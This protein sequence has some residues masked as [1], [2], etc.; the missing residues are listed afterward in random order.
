MQNVDKCTAPRTA[1][2]R[3]IMKTLGERDFSAQETMHLLLSLKL[4]ST[5]FNVIPVSLNGSRKVETQQNGS[6][7]CTKDS[8]LDKYAKRSIYKQSFPEIMNVNFVEFATKYNIV[9]GKLV[10][11][12]AIVVPRIFPTYSPNPKGEN[13]S[14]YCK[15]QLLKHKPWKN[16]V[17][18]AWDNADADQETYVDQW[19]NF[20]KT[21]YA[22]NHV[23]HWSEK[24]Q[25]VLENLEQSNDEIHDGEELKQEEWMILSDY[26]NSNKTFFSE[27]VQQS[28]YDWQSNS[29]KYTAQEIAEMPNWIQ[30]KKKI[31]VQVPT[32]VPLAVIQTVSVRSKSL[33][34]T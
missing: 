6:D 27:N 34:M 10:T 1:I 22:E 21:S 30:M 17:D 24:I 20:L 32:N 16:S 2:K 11:R 26:H 28:A 7:T 19:H 23:P 29:L 31:F 13:Y 8:L 5:T 25:N 4:Y 33:H 18:D 9:K 14:M 15:Y 12:S 3:V